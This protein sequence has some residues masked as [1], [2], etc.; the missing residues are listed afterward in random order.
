MS[1]G[2]G[3]RFRQFD[4]KKWNTG[5]ERVFGKKPTF[6]ETIWELEKVIDEAN[7]QE[8]E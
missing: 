7:E 6:F 4:R 5:Y 1:A 3:D 2:K 8:E